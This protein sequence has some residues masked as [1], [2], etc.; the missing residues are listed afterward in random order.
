MASAAQAERTRPAPRESGVDPFALLLRALSGGAEAGLLWEPDSLK[1]GAERL[2]EQASSV[3]G[4][5]LPSKG[6]CFLALVQDQGICASLC[7]EMQGKQARRL[8]AIAGLEARR[9]G[10]S[11]EE[12]HKA[13]LDHLKRQGHRVAMGMTWDEA[14]PPAQGRMSDPLSVLLKGMDAGKVLLDPVPAKLGLG[15]AGLRVLRAFEIR[16]NA[17]AGGAAQDLADQ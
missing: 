17:G 10:Q 8:S 13:I 11:L 16:H 3:L 1:E 7:V 14:W 4:H 5:A 12:H 9:A 6:T 15:L 2:L